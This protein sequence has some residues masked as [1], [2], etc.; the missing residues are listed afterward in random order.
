MSD[1]ACP[2][3]LTP[4]QRADFDRRVRGREQHARFERNLRMSTRVI[5]ETGVELAGPDS[6]ALAPER[7]TAFVAAPVGRVTREQA[8]IL[9]HGPMVVSDEMVERALRVYDRSGPSGHT[10]DR[11]E[12]RRMLAAA[13]NG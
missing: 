11:A 8:G 3:E 9:D 4:G 12:I 1:Y 10:V 7:S 13:L 6:P 2:A 5:D